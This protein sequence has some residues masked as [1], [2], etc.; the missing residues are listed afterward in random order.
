MQ[1]TSP[2]NN[3]LIGLEQQA[4]E[5]S[6]GMMQGPNSC[7][8][9]G[10]GGPDGGDK[11]GNKTTKKKSS[12][13]GGG[14]QKLSNSNKKNTAGVETSQNIMKANSLHLGQQS[15]SN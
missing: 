4:E 13:V 10:N 3:F 1:A 11:K 2:Y 15:S 12:G 7:I 6:A 5:E 14:V 8:P 9:M